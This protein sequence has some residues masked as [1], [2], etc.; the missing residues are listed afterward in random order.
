MIEEEHG[1]RPVRAMCEALDVAPSAYYAW[2]GRSESARE[3]ADRALLVEI[4]AVHRESRQTY[5][6]LRVGVR[7]V[8]EQDC[9]VGGR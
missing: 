9:P 8:M 2:R 3:R 1:R 4:R 5:G 6:A 7:Q